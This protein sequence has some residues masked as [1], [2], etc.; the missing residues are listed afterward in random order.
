MAAGV[1]QDILLYKKLMVEAAAVAAV[2]VTALEEHHQLTEL[3]VRKRLKQV[4]GVME[5]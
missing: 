3:R 1:L 5:L 4:V 2:L